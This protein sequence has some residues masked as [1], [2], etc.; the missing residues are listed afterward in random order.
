MAGSSF[1]NLSASAI[2]NNNYAASSMTT[3]V[4]FSASL[5]KADPPPSP[6]KAGLPLPRWAGGVALVLM[7]CACASPMDSEETRV[8]ASL[9]ATARLQSARE[10]E[11]QANWRGKAYEALLAAYGSPQFMMNAVGYRPLKT[12]L[13]V[14][15]VV[16]KASNCVD[17]FSMVKNEQTGEWTVAD[18]FCR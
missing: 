13:V 7:L 16:D 5:D 12:S 3:P 14:F 2:V 1:R 4:A 18:Y 10:A 8:R 6:K 11:L 17:T 15:G 9:R